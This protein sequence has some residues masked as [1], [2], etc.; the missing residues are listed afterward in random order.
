MAFDV[1]VRGRLIEI[2]RDVPTVV[3]RGRCTV[4]AREGFVR[5]SWLDQDRNEQGVTLAAQRFE[6]Y[7][8]A[9]A[10]IIVDAAQISVRP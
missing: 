3:P 2:E 1:L 10:I 5:L 9:G 7:L 6:E 4:E 8:E